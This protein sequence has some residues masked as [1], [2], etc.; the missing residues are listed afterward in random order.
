MSENDK[1]NNEIEDIPDVDSE[2]GESTE[3]EPEVHELLEDAR[4][5]ADEH[6]DQLLRAQAELENMRR[7]VQRDVSN[8]HKFAIEKFVQELLPV[9]D[10]LEMA[11]LAAE[12]AASEGE[13]ADT[14]HREGIELTL[15][16]LTAAL[17]KSGLSEVNP[18]DQPFDPEFHQAMSMSETADK[19]PNTVLAV[20]QK[21][22]LLHDRLVRPAM[23]VV[24]RAP[25]EA[26][27]A[28]SAVHIDE[29]T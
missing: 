2:M 20:M 17:E 21:G 5:K 7:R 26:Q 3:S 27:A 1:D 18:L 13:G 4:A 28:E 15:K 22:Y 19:A 14:G 10:S 11:L 6:W 23:V 24:S 25:A 29:K 16:M 8:A 12:P 9:K